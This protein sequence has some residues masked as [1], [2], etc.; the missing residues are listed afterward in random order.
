M[1]TALTHDD[2]LAVLGRAD[3][4]VIAK[5]IASG[6]TREELMKAYAWHTNDEALVNEGRS[7]PSGRIGEL[8]SIMSALE[9]EKTADPGDPTP[10]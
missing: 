7:L 1:M 5:I 4:V 2:V 10:M 3:D 8:I 6:A 9:E